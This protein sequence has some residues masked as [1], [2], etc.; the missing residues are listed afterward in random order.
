MSRY[1]EHRLKLTDAEIERAFDGGWGDEF[2]PVLSVIQAARLA[3]VS[4]KTL[5]DWSHRGL[6]R[7]CAARVGKRLRIFR[8][9]FVRFLF[10]PK[11]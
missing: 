1:A 6:L 4:T 9:R 10:E 2:P 11:E 3:Q 7:G 8:D 5:Y